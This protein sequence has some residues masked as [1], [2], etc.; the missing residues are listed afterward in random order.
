VPFRPSVGAGTAGTLLVSHGIGAAMAGAPREP[1]AV[2]ARNGLTYVDCPELGLSTAEL[3]WLAA[4]RNTPAVS[5]LREAARQ[6]S[7]VVPQGRP[8]SSLRA[9]G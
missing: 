6:G 3:A 2:A 4:H 9:D 7:A 8:R 1:R 5:A